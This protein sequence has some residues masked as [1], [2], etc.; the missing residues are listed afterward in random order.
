M[1]S[2]CV[3]QTLRYCRIRS[4][5]QRPTLIFFVDIFTEF[6]NSWS[7]YAD[8]SPTAAWSTVKPWLIDSTSIPLIQVSRLVQ[9]VQFSNLHT[10]YI[11]EILTKSL[12]S[13]LRKRSRCPYKY[14]R[15][16]WPPNCCKKFSWTSSRWGRSSLAIS[17]SSPASSLPSTLTSVWWSLIPGS[18]ATLQNC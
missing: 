10:N 17:P 8:C 3:A 14:I 11:S 1:Y 16:K 2:V 13:F 18:W 7:R 5:F 4:N 9:E 6:F 12:L 15:R